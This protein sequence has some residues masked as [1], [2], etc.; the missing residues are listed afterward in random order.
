MFM[1]QKQHVCDT[2]YHTSKV[3]VQLFVMQ[4][5]EHTVIGPRNIH[6]HTVDP[7]VESHPK[8]IHQTHKIPTRLITHQHIYL[9]PDRM[10][11]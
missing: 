7:R 11:K 3:A 8:C 2:L 10:E 5:K 4:S 9:N 1:L 6:L